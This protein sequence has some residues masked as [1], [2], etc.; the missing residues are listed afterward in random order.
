L[1][2]GNELNQPTDGFNEREMDKLIRQI[3]DRVRINYFQN[4]ESRGI[5]AEVKRIIEANIERI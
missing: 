5:P 2:E 4:G 3:V 1:S